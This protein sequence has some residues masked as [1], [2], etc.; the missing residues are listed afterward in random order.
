[1]C[2]ACF[3]VVRRGVVR[4]GAGILTS[5]HS[6]AAGSSAG[7]LQEANSRD[8]PAADSTG[9]AVL[10]PPQS[11]SA[12]LRGPVG[13]HASRGA[14]TASASHHHGAA[15]QAKRAVGA[16]LSGEA[17]G[18]TEAASRAVAGGGKGQAHEGAR[19]QGAADGGRRQLAGGS[20]S[21]ERTNPAS[22]Q[23]I[24]RQAERKSK[25]GQEED[26][27]GA[28]GRL[29]AVLPAALSEGGPASSGPSEGASELPAWGSFVGMLVQ[30]GDLQESASSYCGHAAAMD[31]CVHKCV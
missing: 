25:P 5:S 18:Q 13:E 24:A 16:Q 30:D 3:G 11:R 7:H 1:M 29:G 23:Q 4:R 12:A 27:E 2:V 21:S 22:D 15:A 31:G 17:T 28:D 10:L 8:A 9:P 26:P 19:R 20:G 14:G 6:R